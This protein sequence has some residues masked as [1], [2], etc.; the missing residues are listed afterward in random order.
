MIN[1]GQLRELVIQTNSLL[2]DYLRITEVQS[3]Y[4]SMLLQ[5]IQCNLKL[6]EERYPEITFSATREH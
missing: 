3:N 2:D 5:Q 1:K 6:M 4:K